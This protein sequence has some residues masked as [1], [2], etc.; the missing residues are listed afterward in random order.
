[1]ECINTWYGDI[2]KSLFK[3]FSEIKLLVLDVDGVFSDGRIYL[4]NDGEELK[5]FHTRDGFGMK[6]LKKSGVET[7][8]ITGRTSRIV[9]HR[10]EHLDVGFIYQGQNDKTAA[11]DEL[12]T[13]LGLSAE[14]VAYVGD[15]T[16]DLALI[17]AAGLGIAVQDAH[18]SVQQ[19]ADYISR[20]HG[21][22]GAVREVCDL[23]ML[24]QGQ[25]HLA[26]G[27]SV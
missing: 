5:A 11:F 22:H 25:L 2:E 24:S 23:I 20:C 7:A 9:E 3:R 12:L 19:Q 27:A 1:M 15:D 26:T 6:A 8:V 18:A 21:G 10:M 4:G 14:Q 13:K 17:K 16:P